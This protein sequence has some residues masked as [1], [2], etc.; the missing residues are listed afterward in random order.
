[1]RTV[2]GSEFQIDGAEDRKACLQKSVLMNSWSS[3]GTAEECKKSSAAGTFC[4]SLKAPRCTFRGGSPSLLL[5][6]QCHY[7]LTVLKVKN[8]KT[9]LA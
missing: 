3:S 6:L 4:D 1:M 7:L 5:A 9:R 8:A 2:C